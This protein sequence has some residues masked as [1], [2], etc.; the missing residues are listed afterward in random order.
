MRIALIRKY[1]RNDTLKKAKEERLQ[2]MFESFRI[3]EHESIEDM[4]TR[5]TILINEFIDVG[6]HLPT[7][8]IV[9]MF[10]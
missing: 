2:S 6:D 5:F 10:I 7:N 9:T 1:E 8:K 4:Y 3:D